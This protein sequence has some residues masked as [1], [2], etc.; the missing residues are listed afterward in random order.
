MMRLKLG[1]IKSFGFLNFAGAETNL[2]RPEIV[3]SDEGPVAA[4]FSPTEGRA[5]ETAGRVC[6]KLNFRMEDSNKAFR[7]PFTR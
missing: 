1:F 6:L 2:G 7:K 4:E 3:D 5:V